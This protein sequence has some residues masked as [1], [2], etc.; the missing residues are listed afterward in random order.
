MWDADDL[1]K[2]L[3]ENYD[4][5]SDEMKSEIPMKRIWILLPEED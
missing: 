1:I 2:Q 4:H 3:I 5:L